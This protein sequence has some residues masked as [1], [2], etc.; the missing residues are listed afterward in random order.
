MKC[1]EC[2]QR[3]H[4]VGAEAWCSA[5]CKNRHMLRMFGESGNDAP[6]KQLVE[7]LTPCA[8]RRTRLER[9]PSYGY[10]V[11]G[12]FGGPIKIGRSVT[13]ERRIVGL[14]IGSPVELEF[15]ATWDERTQTEAAIHA[16]FDAERIRGEWFRPTQRILAWLR[17]INGWRGPGW[18]RLFGASVVICS[19]ANCSALKEQYPANAVVAL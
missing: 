6:K 16:T 7:S 2:K 11:Q 3:F 14:Q 4:P 19:C 18:D 10:A 9:E 17:E 5:D 15:I 8:A 12:V 13:P 1:A